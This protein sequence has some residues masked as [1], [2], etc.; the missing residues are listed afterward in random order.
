MARLFAKHNYLKEGATKEELEAALA[1]SG[2]LVLEGTAEL[3]GRADAKPFRDRQNTAFILEQ[4]LPLAVAMYNIAVAARKRKVGALVDVF[5]LG[6]N[7]YPLVQGYLN[8]GK[9]NLEDI[10]NAISKI[11]SRPEEEDREVEAV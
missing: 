5:T 10:K 4:P 2:F 3:L 9:L 7:L 6:F 1:S 11:E 8:G